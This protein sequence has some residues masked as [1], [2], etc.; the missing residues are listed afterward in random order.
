MNE[1]IYVGV[2]DGSVCAFKID[3]GSLLWQTSVGYGA[4]LGFV[5][6]QL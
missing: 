1:V 5:D 2:N 6:V 3:D 4:S